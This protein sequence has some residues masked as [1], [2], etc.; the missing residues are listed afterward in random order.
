MIVP[1][2][3]RRL[4]YEDGDLIRPGYHLEE[5]RRNGMIFGGGGAFVGF[6]VASILTGRLAQAEVQT[7]NAIGCSIGG[8]VNANATCSPPPDQYWPMYI[9]LVGPFVTMGTSHAS[10]GGIIGL[11]VLGLGQM[12]GLALLITGMVT[13]NKVLVRNDV[14][15]R[16]PTLMPAVGIGTAGIRGTF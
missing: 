9:P 3:P 12:G 16:A 7:G 10:G 8:I 6:W 4:D 5:Q 11:S 13:K 1:L 15:A 14:Q 2:G